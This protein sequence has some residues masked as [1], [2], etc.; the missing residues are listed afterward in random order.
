MTR[1]NLCDYSDASIHVKGTITVPNIAGTDAAVNN[2][3]KKVILK[4]S[5]SFTNCISEIND[6]QVDDA[7]DID[8]AMPMYNLIEYS[9][10]Y[11]K[12]SR[13]LSQYY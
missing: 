3:N 13:S 9:D 7:Q 6:I 11:S 4:N 2:T 10:D 5:V 8:T 1:P 12:T